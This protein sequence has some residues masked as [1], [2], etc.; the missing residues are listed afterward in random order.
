MYVLS[1][2]LIGLLG[3]IG[4]IGLYRWSQTGASKQFVIGM[5]SWLSCLLLFAGVFKITP[6]PLSLVFV[7]VAVIHVAVVLGWDFF[8][9]GTRLSS[10]ETLGLILAVAG[11]MMMELK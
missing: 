3:A 6:R 8:I 4:D 7:T 11:L 2:L 10:R 9:E 5:A 1:V